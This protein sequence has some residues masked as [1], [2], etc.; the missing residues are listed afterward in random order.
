MPECYVIKRG[1]SSC[2]TSRYIGGVGVEMKIFSI[3]YFLNDPLHCAIND[4]KPAK[5]IL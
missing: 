4:Q 1:I 5:G 3:T 2:L